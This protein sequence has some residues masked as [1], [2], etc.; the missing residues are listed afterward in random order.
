MFVEDM[1]KNLEEPEDIGIQKNFSHTFE[2]PGV[3]ILA[4][5]MYKAYTTNEDPSITFTD[6]MMTGLG[7]DGWEVTG[8]VTK[9]S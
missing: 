9:N 4:H 1:K 2:D 7:S 3:E 5:L 6:V 8:K